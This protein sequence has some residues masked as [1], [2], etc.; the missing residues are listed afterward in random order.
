MNTGTYPILISIVT[1]LNQSCIHLNIKVN[2]SFSSFIYQ[3]MIHF[4][5]GAVICI[6]Y[7]PA[8]H[9]VVIFGYLIT[10]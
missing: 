4:P 2:H 5:N 9:I 10:G 6:F 8:A 3:Q 7:I 1:L